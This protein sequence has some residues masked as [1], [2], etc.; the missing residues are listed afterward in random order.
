MPEQMRPKP[1]TLSPDP[2][3]SYERS[4]PQRE[5]G[6]GRLDNNSNATPT[7]RTDSMPA[8]VENAQDGSIQI[9]ASDVA[10]TPTPIQD[11][12]GW[13]VKNIGKSSK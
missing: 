13:D 3:F 5:A 12:L 10:V 1:K 9:N 11:P 6:Q 8:S 4:H 7:P 2:S